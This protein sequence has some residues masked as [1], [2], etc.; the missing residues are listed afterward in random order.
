[1]S[2]LDAPVRCIPSVLQTHRILDLLAGAQQSDPNAPV[3]IRGE[4]GVG[5]DVMARLIH[6]TSA[7]QP[8]S[9]IKVNCRAQALDP[10]GDLFGRE[11]GPGMSRRRPGSF[12]YANH[13]TIYLDEISAMP[14]GLIAELGRVLRT[15]EILGA[16]TETI[17]RVDVRVIASTTLSTE[18]GDHADLWEELR[19]WNAHEIYI[20][21]LRERIDEVASFASFF[22]E[23]FGRQFRRDVEFC[24]E[25]MTALEAHSWPGNIRELEAA[26]HRLVLGGVHRG[27]RSLAHIV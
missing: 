26:V 18:T 19:G 20:P 7:R 23:Q 2:T 15:G 6:A 3:V 5:K 27:S 16:H 12:E 4:P 21:P 11:R 13:G 9:F 25:V 8:Y 14:L 10:S 1:M 22:G 17:A 24:P